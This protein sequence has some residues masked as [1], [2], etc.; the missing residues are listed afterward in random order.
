MVRIGVLGLCG[1]MAAVADDSPD[2]EVV[3]RIRHEAY[4]N[5]EVMDHLFQL[6]EVYGPRVTNSPG[7][8]D[9]AKWAVERFNEWGLSNAAMEA[10]GPFGQGWSREYYSAH[11][12]APQY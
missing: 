3:N 6:V 7:F 4:E 9:S 11:L 2:L 1:V 8:L 12:T 10:W 5:S